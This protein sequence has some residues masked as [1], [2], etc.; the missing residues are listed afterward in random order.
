MKVRSKFLIIDDDPMV[1][2]LFHE[3]LQMDGH[4]AWIARTGEEGLRLFRELRPHLV[5]LDVYLPDADGRHVCSEIKRDPTS[6]DTFV[7]LVSGDAIQAEE[8][9]AGLHAGADDY[10]SKPVA[11]QEF[12]ARIHTLL[13]LRETTVAL[14]EREAHYRRLVQ[15][16]PDAVGVVNRSG[17]VVSANE[18]AAAMLGYEKWEDLVGTHVFSLV[19]RELHKFFRRDVASTLREGATPMREYQLF[20][21]DGTPLPVEASAGV[22]DDGKGRASGFIITCRD[23]TF[24]KRAE[25]RIK[26]LL[27][28]LDQAHDAILVR[29]LEG[30]VHFLNHGAE[31]LFGWKSEEAHGLDARSV[32]LQT[33]AE[34]EAA[35]KGLLEDGEWSGE[36]E[37]RTREGNRVMVFSH[38]T[39][40]H[41]RAGDPPSVVV[42]NTDITSRK[43]AE[44]RLRESESLKKAILDTISDPAWLKDPEGRFLDGNE[45]LARFFGRKLNEVLGKTPSELL[46]GKNA[47]EAEDREVMASKRPALFEN[48]G[49]DASGRTRWFETYRS[50]LVNENGRCWGIVGISRD[51]TDR[52]QAHQL[53]QVQRDFGI[54]LAA[55]NDLTATAEML[56][57]FVTRIE[58][59]DCAALFLPDPKTDELKLTFSK[60]CATDLAGKS[61]Q[62]TANSLRK[63]NHEA[64]EARYW[65]SKE[66][67]RHMAE[68]AAEEGLL[69]FGAIPIHHAGKVVAVLT[70]G[71]HQIE[72]LP[73]NSRLLAE[74][75]ATQTGGA[76]AR[77]RAEAE[78]R[79]LPMRI[80]EAQEAERQRVAR[81]LHDGVN[82]IIASAKMKLRT[83]IA[84]SAGVLSP[85]TKE[86]LSRCD[87]LLVRA[88]A[89][90]RTI[91]HGLR[92][93]ELD[94][95]GLV[96]ASRIY[97]DE[98]E[99]RSGLRIKRSLMQYEQRLPAAMELNLFRILQEALSNAE[100]HANAEEVS[101]RLWIQDETVRLRIQDDGKGF[102]PQEPSSFASQGKGI[103][104]TNLRER[105]AAFGGTFAVE[106][107]PKKGTTV[108]VT[109]PFAQAKAAEI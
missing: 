36:L 72:N 71:S 18:S 58:G 89:E 53:M 48:S 12:L 55:T 50:P 99:S 102:N 85:M 39:L 77:I 64:G 82:Q 3:V 100:K 70:L 5:L 13:R 54:F 103:G 81:E 14:R 88:L 74:A 8:K 90:N 69:A 60:G 56:T 101:V 20:R 38:W 65:R 98:V 67:P 78:L 22:L 28:L 105:A 57:D 34:F 61:W 2:Q 6:T 44:S 24:R 93:A 62:R 94:Q 19:P 25:K 45:S 35:R 92:P 43:A 106:S 63:S 73:G 97:C 23:L 59:V 30:T 96:T 86:L 21:K 79:R 32:L 40:A 87:D 68:E 10:M 76:L 26:D 80:T 41:S 9:A 104:L 109:I 42:I 95:L 15:L 75:L 17:T 33:D 27:H 84:D 1:A 83:I 66:F 91:A 107:A 108:T 31:R 16:L 37:A 7:V 29:D 11:I 51:V 4:E 52:R 47:G 49:V 46:P